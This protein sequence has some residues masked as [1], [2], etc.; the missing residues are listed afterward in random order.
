MSQ[1]SPSK[2]ESCHA[3]VC[4]LIDRFERHAKDRY[5][6]SNYQEAEVRKDF[7]DP[8]FKALGW[9]VDHER[10]HN[11]Y[12]QEVKVERAVHMHRSKKRADY[13]FY[14]AP[15]FNNVRFFLEAKKP[16]INLEASADAHFQT[17]RYGYSAK[18]PLAILT[19]FEQV[20]V[21]DCRRVPA[22]VS[23]IEQ[24]W[25]S[26]HYS[27]FREAEVF[28]EFYYLFSREAHT[29]GSYLRRLEDLPKSADIK[30]RKLLK[31][32]YQ[33]VDDRFLAELEGH[34]K[35]LARIFK[36]ADASLDSETL[37][38][39]VQRTLDRLVFLRFL[40]DKQIETEIGISHFGKRKGVW[41]D[42][43]EASR[44]LDNIYNGII[45]KHIDALDRPSLQVDDAE[46]AVVCGGLSPE[47]SPYNFDVI[48]IHILGSIY[49]QFLGSVIRATG[50]DVFVEQRPEVRKAGGVYYTPE[51]IVRYI[52]RNTVGRLIQGKTPREIAKMRFADIS[53]GSGSFLL[54]IFDELLRYHSA[55]YNQPGREKQAKRDGCVLAEG[56]RWRL[57]LAQR[58]SILQ[59]N[60]Y[61][62]D[63][64]RQAVEVAQMSLFLKLLEDERATSARQYQLEYARDS[65]MK[66]LLPDLSLNIVCGNSLIG[67]DAAGITALDSRDER[68]L[69][70]LDIDSAFPSVVDAGGFDAVVGNPPYVDSEWMTKHSP[71]MREFCNKVYQAASGNWDL[72]CV[73]VER[74]DALCKPR[75]LVSLILPNK[76]GSA[77]YAKGARKVLGGS[78]LLSIRDYSSVPVFPVSVY[79]IVYISEKANPEQNSTVHF[80]KM[81]VDKSGEVI[82]AQS[83]DLCLS[84][85]SPPELPWRVFSSTSESNPAERI[86]AR[87]PALGSIATVVGAATVAEAYE[88]AE[89]VSEG[90]DGIRVV[91]S[92]TIDPHIFLWGQKQFRYL[93]STYKM[94][95]VAK[96][97]WSALPPRRLA[98]ARSPKI[99]IA[100]MTKSL[101]CALDEAG[102]YLAGKSTTLVLSKAHLKYLQGILSSSLISFFYD[103][104]FGGD[105]LQGG[106]LRVGPPQVKVIP[107]RQIDPSSKKDKVFEE[108]MSRLVDQI[109]IAKQ[110]EVTASGQAREIASRKCAALQRQINHLV[111]ELYELTPEEVAIV[112]QRT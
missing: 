59:S 47:N 79:P 92:G 37:T 94:P 97:S 20:R 110:Q 45:Y 70:P 48:P 106:Y 4:E 91:N 16:S 56:N 84:Y 5:L 51:Y 82:V 77:N 85:F 42:F 26:W 107:I 50:K 64:D 9:D 60:V 54:G 81:E 80:E 17:L 25:K 6:Q 62:I 72:F 23:A 69:N 18:T 38:E 21:L 22:Q 87:Y 3:R 75:G 27:K 73:F 44:R 2:F 66:K 15:D 35:L 61:G 53:C 52:V 68:H 30:R 36:K 83:K 41:S 104:Q 93:K 63:I 112:S 19:D 96:A 98:Q 33:P 101:E 88:I 109:A 67:W 78:T 10:E 86:R 34:R 13:A 39:I 76:L 12:E 90:T 95:V 102:S 58:R 29:D 8:F 111:F 31:S 55:W 71:L 7:I 40:E 32:E 49:E 108:Q 57:S 28:A 1:T 65:N 11:P 105:R 89:L 46:F 100:G 43:L 24:V 14:L 99:I 103:Y 74:A